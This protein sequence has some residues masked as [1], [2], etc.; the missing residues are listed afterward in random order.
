MEKCQ[1]AIREASQLSDVGWSHV[2]SQMH[3][4]GV[5][6]EYGQPLFERRIDDNLDLGTLG[7]QPG[8]VSLGG[9]G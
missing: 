3:S 6:A 9:F 1:W 2:A 5:H 8:N 4:C 7:H